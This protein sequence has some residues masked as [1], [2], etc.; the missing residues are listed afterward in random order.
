MNLIEETFA[1][2][3]AVSWE[4]GPLKLVFLPEVGG[5]IISLKL[6]GEELFF[7]HPDLL[8]TTVD[9]DRDESLDI[10]KHRIGFPLW[11]GDKIW[12]A[13]QGAWRMDAPSI[14]L[15][16]GR[17]LWREEEDCI[18]MESPVCRETRA[19]LSRRVTLLDGGRVA[20]SDR[21]TNSGDRSLMRG[22]WNVTQCLRPMKV[23]APCPP[24]AWRPYGWEGESEAVAGEVI[25]PDG[26]GSAILCER[27]S[28]FK[29]GAM[30]QDARLTGVRET[31]NKRLFFE[32]TFETNPNAALYAHGANAEVYNDLKQ[33]YLEIEAH[34]SQVRLQPGQSCSFEQ[35]WRFWAEDL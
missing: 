7:Q 2:W 19:L 8:G 5:R 28:H 11:G 13:P 10:A 22:I 33:N 3:P 20:L 25:Q 9:L 17:W 26:E 16:S 6:E 15:D 4:K 23:L 34:A 31:K 30:L 14:D 27:A 24:S 35:L 12:L 18:V 29:M 32:R 1:G 21:L